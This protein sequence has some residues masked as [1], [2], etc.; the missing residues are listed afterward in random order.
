MWEGIDEPLPD[1]NWPVIAPSPLAV[2]LAAT[3][4]RGR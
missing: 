3:R 2:Q 4:C 1:G